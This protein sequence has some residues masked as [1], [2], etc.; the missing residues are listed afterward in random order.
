MCIWSTVLYRFSGITF[1]LEF[2]HGHFFTSGHKGF[3]VSSV[4]KNSPDN[5]G[6]AS[7]IPESGRYPGEGNGNPLWWT[8]VHGVPKGVRHDT[9][10]KQQK[11]KKFNYVKVP[12]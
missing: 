10:T 5:A 8:T 2:Y 7:S 6:V 4:V 1:L 3:P 11:Q 9:V 12:H